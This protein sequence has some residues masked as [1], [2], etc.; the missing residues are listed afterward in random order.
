MIS[1]KQFTFN[2]FAE[3]TYII[4]NDAKE[5]LIIDPGCSNAYEIEQ[6]TNYIEKN[7]LTPVRLLNTHCHVDHIPGNPIMAEKYNL[8]LE[9]HAL[10]ENVLAQA[11]NYGPMFGIEIPSQ[12]AVARFLKDGDVEAFGD[13][14]FHVLHTP[15]HSPGSVCFYFPKAKII[16]A[17][18]VL[19]KGSV[20]RYDLPG[21]N[22]EDLFNSISKTLMALPDDV[23]VFSGHGPKT[24]IGEER[25]SNPFLNR[26]FFFQ[27]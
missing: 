10:E 15:G 21:S 2:P 14:E 7:G 4:H 11:P 25:K 24:T 17:G 5:C 13:N 22:G 19:F 27:L 20:G 3:N 1:L 18:D 12:P 26:A 16:V 6:V 8:G 23:I 9:I